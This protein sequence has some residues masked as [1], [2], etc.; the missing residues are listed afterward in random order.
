MEL[1]TTHVGA[2]FDGFA[3]MLLAR[4]LHPAA[5]LFF[6]GSR[7]RSVRRMLIARGSEVEEI[8]QKEVDA[9]AIERVILCDIRQRT[10]LGIIP[11]WLEENPGIEVLA[12]DHHP[13]D[14]KDVPVTGGI[15]DPMAG[16][17]CTILVE[18]LQRRTLAVSS[19]EATLALMGIYEDTGSLSYPT[20]SPRDLVAAAWLLEQGA[21]LAA[22]RR[23]ALHSLDAGHLEIL[24]RMTEELDV[25][26]IRG[27]RV[28][29]VAIELGR[30]V[31]ELAPLVSRCLEIFELPLLFAI[32]GE[33]DRVTVIA[34][35]EV[36]GVH[37]GEIL[38]ELI[39]G[40][41]HPTAASGNRKGE[42]CLEVRERLLALLPIRLPMEASARDLMIPNFV[43]IDHR[44]TVARAKELLVESK[45]NAAPVLDGSGIALGSVTRQVLDAA[46]QHDLGSRGID[47][48]MHQ[49]LAWVAPEV[50]AE[51]LGSLMTQGSPR[52]LLVGEAGSP[53]LGL[54]TRTAV[55]RHLHGR[56]EEVSDRLERRTLESRERRQGV[57]RLLREAL[58][59]ELYSKIER[60]AE[61][62]Q[63]VGTQVY[64]VGGLVRDVLLRREN[65]D[66]DLVVVGDGPQFARR[67]AAVLE[68]DVR[69]HDAFLTA[70]IEEPNGFVID[71]ATARSEFYRS[72]ASLPEVR[73]SA[74]RQ[75]LYRRDFTVNAL[76][77]QLGPEASLQLVD[78][79]GGQ[80]DLRD[81]TL[82]VLHSLSFIDDPTRVLRAVR[83]ELRLDF[84]LSPETLRLIHIAVS[85]GVFGR[86]SGPRFREELILLLDHP[87]AIRGL[88]RLQELGVLATL[89]PNLAVTPARRRLLEKARGAWDWL[90]LEGIQ[91]FPVRLWLL[92]FL[93]L[94]LDLSHV[95]REQLADRLRLNE[96]DREAL[97]LYT[98]R[99][100][101]T[102]RQLAAGTV[103]PHQVRRVLDRL[104][105]EEILLLMTASEASVRGW[106]R[107]Y[108]VDLRWVAL[109]IQGRD[110]LAGGLSAG[111]LVGEVLGSTLDA[112]LDGRIG[113]TE[114][115]DF[116][117]SLAAES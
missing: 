103:P 15:V 23:F 107:R 59:T 43:A 115:L 62:A 117:L 81:R 93:A 116:A 45:V 86:L 18:E 26:R 28:G 8:R 9:G 92:L 89:S 112:R 90:Q 16:A 49:D 104:S 68:A 7:E 38:G 95:D 64:V 91:D 22:V 5:K 19:E 88:E 85:E 110:L 77:I 3:S 111:P 50:S 106:V 66:V 40:G 32:F 6:P 58:S 42:T 100:G 101:T 1:I 75:D 71:V 99:L 41:G 52:F 78:Y 20:T 113:A 73:T 25:R 84:D 60:I 55:L 53:P 2:D 54:V 79:F 70:R 94:C 10:R 24:H 33:G 57:G 35:G 96:K 13:D 67:L 76:A 80:R 47:R 72:P 44:V 102:R 65:R 37:L 61:V 39:G 17:T 74:L 98:G 31:A 11:Q 46:L 21:D 48:V 30:Y 12:Y 105:V 27:H 36:E 69:V 56:L 51:D 82:R 14:E 108:L 114:E 29:V 63:E 97:R 109:S 34:R 87:S 4:R 83:L